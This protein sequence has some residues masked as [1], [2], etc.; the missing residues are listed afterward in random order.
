MSPLDRT[1]S[2]RKDGE[3]KSRQRGWVGF[4]TTI[5]VTLCARA[6]RDVSLRALSP[7]QRDRLRA[8]LLGQAQ[9]L[10]QPLAIRVRHPKDAGVSTYTA[11]HVAC[12]LLAI[13]RAARTRRADAGLALTQTR[14]RSAVGQTPWMPCSVLYVRM[15]ASTRS[16]TLRSDSSRNAMRLPFR[17]KLSTA[18]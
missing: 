13:R 17:K 6:K 7:R 2:S 10:R 4:P 5:L 16:A 9:V 3:K 14:I 11:M 1:T 15:S 18:R 12:R 8:E